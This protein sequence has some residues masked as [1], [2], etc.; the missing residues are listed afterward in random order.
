MLVVGLNGSPKSSGNTRFLIDR[1]LKTAEE[2]GAQTEAVNISQVF[3]TTEHCFCRVCSNPCTGICYKGKELE[4]V[5]E[6]I[7]KADGIILGSPVYFGTVSAQ[8]KA[9]F[10]KTRKLRK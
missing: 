5:F 7:R 10:D 8:L 3:N 2:S 4:N 6:L 1:V 9:F